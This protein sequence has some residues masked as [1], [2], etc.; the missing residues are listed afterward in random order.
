M[1]Y[2]LQTLTAPA[3]DLETLLDHERKIQGRVWDLAG[4]QQ[5]L[6]DNVLN[7]NVSVQAGNQIVKELYWNSSQL[8][9]FVL[10]LHKAR[11]DCSEWVYISSEPKSNGLSIPHACDVYVMG[12]NKIKGCENDKT[13]PW[14]YCKFTVKNGSAMLISTC[15][16]EKPKGQRK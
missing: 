6:R 2:S 14:V 11:Y 7:L 13:S 5:A 16:P 10:S 9:G 12:Y 1:A 8:T 15:H 3:A 4:V